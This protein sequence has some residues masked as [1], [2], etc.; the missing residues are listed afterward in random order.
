MPVIEPDNPELKNLKG[1]HL[2]HA[3]LSTCSQRARITLAELG[4]G[5]E[6]ASEAYQQIHPN[7]VVPAMVHDGTLVIESI[8]IIAYLDEKLG[9]GRLR[10]V[11]QE[12][13]IE[14]L[15]SQADGAQPLLK[16]CT[17][18]F[19]F[20]AGPPAAD[21]VTEAYQKTHHSE[22]LK[23]FHRDFQAGFERSRVHAAV[24]HV[25]DDFQRLDRSFRDGRDWLAGKEFSL[26]DIAW[27][28]NFHRFELIGLPFDRYPQLGRWFAAAAARDSYRIALEE[29][30][31]QG[32]IDVVMPKLAARRD[33]G[34]GIETYGRLAGSR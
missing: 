24:D 6:Q 23:Q 10:P 9:N 13:D 27:M 32:F 28:P 26:A 34:D 21:A 14:K 19:L 5:G 12:R 8:D 17:F 15:L 3:G 25:H 29:W 11:A 4:L 1:I 16:L 2:W 22:Q 20:R 33:A 7:G 18:E 31:P 30:E